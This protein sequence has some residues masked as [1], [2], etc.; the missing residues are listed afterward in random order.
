M[1]RMIAERIDTLP[2]L[3]EVFREYGYNGASLSVISKAT[4]LGK[5]SLYNFFP[6]GKEEMMVTVLSEIDHW[7]ENNIFTPLIEHESAFQAVS[8]M[9][10]NVEKYFR[11][12][13]R[14]CLIG[15]LA[16][17]DPEDL[18]AKTVSN[19]FLRWIETLTLALKRLNISEPEYEAKEIIAEIQG[20]IVLTRA[21]DDPDLFS[22][23]IE[24]KRLRLSL[25]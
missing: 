23:Y 14:V 3:G 7:F 22:R 15:A 19:Y 12:G 17:N 10:D 21:I 24:K 16:I 13:K 25:N 8:H 9:F 4:G 6:G 1:P 18:F 11:S 20:A 2:A 5:G